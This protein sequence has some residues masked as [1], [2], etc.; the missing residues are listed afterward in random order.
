MLE[1]LK[2][3]A[4][5]AALE[6]VQVSALSQ[7]PAAPRQ[8]EP[9]ARYWQ[10]AVQRQVSRHTMV[11]AAYAGNHAVKLVLLADLNQARVPLPGE[12]VNATLNDRRPYAS[13]EPMTHMAAAAKLA[14]EQVGRVVKKLKQDGLLDDTLIVLTT[15]HAQNT[16]KHFFG[17]DAAGRAKVKVR[18]ASSRTVH[19][20]YWVSPET[21]ITQSIEL[22]V[23]PRIRLEVKPKGKLHKKEKMRVVAI[24]R[25]KWKEGVRVCFYTERPGRNKFGCDKTG[26][27]GRARHGYRPK[28]LGKT[29]FYAKTPNQRG[30]PY[31]NKRSKKKAARIVP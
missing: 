1:G 15:D 5:Q 9:D 16:S 17:V 25:G 26:K 4:G 6:P 3:S 30:Y 28:Q 18:G 23:A 7:A 19:A 27:G 22:R 29:F 13:G 11:E 12:N 20:T 10:F 21:L 31:T 24:L 14:D 2:A 8:V